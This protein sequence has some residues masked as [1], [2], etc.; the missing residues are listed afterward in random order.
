MKDCGIKKSY[1]HTT[2]RF[3]G[4]NQI[5]K[6]KSFILRL[7][8]PFF[9]HEEWR[10]GGTEEFSGNPRERYRVR[11]GNDMLEGTRP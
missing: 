9:S 6:F 4:S 7:Y 2:E 10:N 1:Q 11:T 5:I 8:I 3:T